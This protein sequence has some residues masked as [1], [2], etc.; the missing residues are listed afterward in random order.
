[1][2]FLGSVRQ[3]PGGSFDAPFCHR[4]AGGNHRT[5]DKRARRCNT[6][7]SSSV[8]ADT[9]DDAMNTST[10]NRPHLTTLWGGGGIVIAALLSLLATFRVAV[11]LAH[12]YSFQFRGAIP[13]LLSSIVLAVAIGILA[14][15]I[16]AEAGIVRRSVVGKIALI[17]FG[18]RD[19][20]IALVGM[21]SRNLSQNA[22]AIES[23][24]D[25]AFEV[26]VVVAGVVAAVV[27]VRA[28]VLDGFARWVLVPVAVWNAIIIGVMLIPVIEVAYYF[29]AWPTEIVRPALFI[30][31]G[32]A[33]LL[34]G[35]SAAIRH[36]LQIINENW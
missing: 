3:R 4:C 14:L 28:D 25:L 18:L 8:T 22:L 5:D 1:L 21:L 16:R 26:I 10:L 17:V 31:L 33:Y 13:Q 7:V 27:I 32:A 11:P 24:F 9:K 23:Y 36:R 15:G 29:V 35:Q 6:E 20:V 30:A 12:D 19:V 2:W 34:E